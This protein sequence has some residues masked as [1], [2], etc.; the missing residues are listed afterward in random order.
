MIQGRVE[1]SVVSNVGRQMHSHR[2][3]RLE[4][5]CWQIRG[6]GRE[7]KPDL[8]PGLR[9]S[10]PAQPHEVIEDRRL[11]HVLKDKIASILLSKLDIW[12]L[13][14]FQLGAVEEVL[15]GGQIQHLV[16][17]SHAHSSSATV[18]LRKNSIGKVVKREVTLV[19]DTNDASHV[20][21]E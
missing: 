3:H 6:L 21:E 16:S 7:Q 19:G 4:G 11:K 20:F 1:I 17:N 9:P 13:V 12:Y 14:V 8:G 18:C 15:H 10:L 5:V 2:R